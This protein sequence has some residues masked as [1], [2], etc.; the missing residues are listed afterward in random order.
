MLIRAR[1]TVVRGDEILTNNPLIHDLS[2]LLP[3][4]IYLYIKKLRLLGRSM[5]PVGL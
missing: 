1:Q 2:V 3:K 4:G 5:K